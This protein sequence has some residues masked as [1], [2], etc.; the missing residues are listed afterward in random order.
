[1]RTMIPQEDSDQPDVINVLYVE[2]DSHQQMFLK[3]FIGE[4]DPSIH[5]E[6]IKSATAALEMIDNSFDCILINY[7]LP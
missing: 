6:T 3:R 1:M 5:V 7:Q 4:M 2:D